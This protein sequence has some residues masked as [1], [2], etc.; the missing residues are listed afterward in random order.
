[1]V[2]NAN[3]IP[4][5]IHRETDSAPGSHRSQPWYLAY[6]DAL[7][8]TDRGR[9][10]ERI[11][12]AERMIIY[13]ERE[14]FSLENSLSEQRALGTALHALRALRSCFGVWRS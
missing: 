9:V 14:L 2:V 7:F 10:R 1:M 11:S 4:S 5:T 12:H 13:R 6:R 3:P 8:E